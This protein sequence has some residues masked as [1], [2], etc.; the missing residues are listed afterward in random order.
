MTDV[1]PS[2]LWKIIDGISVLKPNCLDVYD[3]DLRV[4]SPIL[5][6]SHLVP[7]LEQNLNN[8]WSAQLN[9]SIFS[10]ILDYYLYTE[11]ILMGMKCSLEGFL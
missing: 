5:I 9:C 11:A 3:D 7:L 2:P 10:M 8:R 1:W 6:I 4:C